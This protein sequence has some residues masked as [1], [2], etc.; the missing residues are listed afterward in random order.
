MILTIPSV[1]SWL[2]AKLQLSTI[3]ESQLLMTDSSLTQPRPWPRSPLPVARCPSRATLQYKPKLIFPHYSVVRTRPV[4]KGIF[5]FSATLPHDSV[6]MT[7]PPG[8]KAED[9]NE[10]TKINKRKKKK[11]NRRFRLSDREQKRERNTKDK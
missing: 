2:V 9:R 10:K 8:P 3:P 4:L 6:S 1:S 5:V 7:E 11:K